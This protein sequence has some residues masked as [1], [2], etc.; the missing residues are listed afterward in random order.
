MVVSYAMTKNNNWK[1][2]ANK[3]L[4]IILISWQ[5]KEKNTISDVGKFYTFKVCLTLYIYEVK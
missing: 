4:E 1:E 3:F 2:I 5:I